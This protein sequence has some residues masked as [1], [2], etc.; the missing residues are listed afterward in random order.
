[1]N[2][3]GYFLSNGLAFLFYSCL[4]RNDALV[5]A[6]RGSATLS[7]LYHIFWSTVLASSNMQEAAVD[8]N[9]LRTSKHLV[10]WP[11]VL[12]PHVTF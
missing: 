5:F 1:M 4:K 6:V 11:T 3:L 8:Q 9:L 2:Y 10:K 7:G 12:I